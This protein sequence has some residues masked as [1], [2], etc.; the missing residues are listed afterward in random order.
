MNH[1]T[2]TAD[3]AAYESLLPLLTTGLLT[4]EETRELVAHAATCAHC[5]AQLDEYAALEAAGRRYYGPDA[6]LPAFVATPLTLDDIVYADASDDV[7]EE[8]AAVLAP[9]TSQR[10]RA[11]RSVWLRILPEIAAILVV[12]LLA[13][14]LLVN[15]PGASNPSIGILPAGENAVVFTHTVPWGQ[16]AINGQVV[17][18]SPHT[19]DFDTSHLNPLYLP[20]KSNTI[21]YTAAPFP[22]F[23]CTISAPASSSDTCP[24]KTIDLITGPSR[25]D[26]TFQGRGIDLQAIPN[27]LPAASLD[28]LIAATQQ[29]LDSSTSSARVLPGDHYIAAD[30]SYA[31]ATQAF[32]MEMAYRV[33]TATEAQSIMLGDERCA[34]FCAGL[35][36]S[37]ISAW[38][39]TGPGAHWT[40]LP[41]V[42]WQYTL[43][44]GQP[45]A[46]DR[47]PGATIDITA[48]WTGSWQVHISQ[49]L[50]QSALDAAISQELASLI[51][52]GG[53]GDG[54][55]VASSANGYLVKITHTQTT[56]GGPNVTGYVLY[57]AGAVVALDDLA[58]QALPWIPVA[59]A[60]ETAIARQ[61]GWK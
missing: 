61:L 51:W 8:V 18:I 10:P 7:F 3:C 59:S 23:Q 34:P 41:V 37:P 32:D 54:T 49:T 4:D 27:G 22:L 33:P 52:S 38:D 17:D 50:Q 11:H 21:T 26:Q 28:A 44:S 43:P 25:P 57:R 42:R 40:L 58:H 56:L 45:V 39:A 13:T 48:N 35:G 30:G 6:T 5:R 12:A 31:T 9:S 60:H 1:S 36:V 15:R 47:G 24:L 29:V 19:A 46:A 20:R 53:I 16:L 55:V 14:T 2:P